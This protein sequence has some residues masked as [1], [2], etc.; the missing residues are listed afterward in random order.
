MRMQTAT[1]ASLIA[2]LA[3]TARASHLAF[4]DN[5]LNFKSCDG[6]GITARWRGMEFSLSEPGK[7]LGDGHASFKFLDWDGNCK[8]VAWDSSASKF[9]IEGEKGGTRSDV[10]RYVAPDGSKWVGMRAGDGF[11]VSRIAQSGEVVSTA[12]VA[13]VAAWLSRTSKEYTPG[14]AMA[15]T[16]KVNPTE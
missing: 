2:I 7:S 16:L 4:E 9:V 12:R 15:E 13:D 8:T 1:I 5:K 6:S 11:F 14:A 3:T 10:I